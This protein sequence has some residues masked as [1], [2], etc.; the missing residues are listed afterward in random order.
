MSEQLKNP[1]DLLLDQIRVIV[2]EEVQ[3]AM[4]NGNGHGPDKLIDVADVAVYLKQSPD[5]VY[6]H[7]KQLG[8]RKLGNKSIRFVRADLDRWLKSRKVTS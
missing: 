3:A 5:Y 7:W 1:F 6:R 4:A 2:R 8:G